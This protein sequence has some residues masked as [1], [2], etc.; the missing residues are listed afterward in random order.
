MNKHICKAKRI[1][2]GEWVYGYYIAAPWDGEIAHFIIEQ[3]TEYK[4]AGEFTWHGVHR[5]NPDTI[6]RCTGIKDNNGNMI[7]EHDIVGHALYGCGMASEVSYRN[8]GFYFG[9]YHINYFNSARIHSNKFDNT[10]LME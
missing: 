2:D 5:V 4:G 7:F 6:C 10:N 1:F 8:G 3:N 9:A